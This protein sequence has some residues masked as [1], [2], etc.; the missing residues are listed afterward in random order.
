MRR[1]VLVAA[2]L[3]IVGAALL[4]VPAAAHDSSDAF[5]CNPTQNVATY[6]TGAGNLYQMD[7]NVCV[8]RYNDAGSFWNIEGMIRYTCFRNGSPWDGCRANGNVE[9]HQAPD[10]SSNWV[11]ER[12]NSFTRPAASWPCSVGENCYFQDSGRISSDHEPDFNDEW[13]RGKNEGNT[14]RFLLADGSNVVVGITN[15]YSGT[16]LCQN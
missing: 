16:C 8:G 6:V 1:L 15:S 4:P 3:A 11:V 2:I 7:V 14:A 10:G 9:V 12:S 5:S 13:A